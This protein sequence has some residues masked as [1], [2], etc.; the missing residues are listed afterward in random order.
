MTSV[1]VSS[2]GILVI[3][4][5]FTDAGGNSTADYIAGWTGSSWS[6]IGGGLNSTVNDLLFADHDVLYVAGMLFQRSLPEVDQLKHA[7][8]WQEAYYG[9]VMRMALL[10]LV[11]GATE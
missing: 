5:S 6:P 1:A 11:L 10:A 7:R 9:V 8:Y 4:G 2:S 3:G